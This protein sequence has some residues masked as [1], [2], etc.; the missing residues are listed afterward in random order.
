MQIGAHVSVAGGLQKA[1]Q[2][3]QAI[4]A[5]IL[6]IFVSGPQS[7][8]TTDYSDSQIE[9]FKKLYHSVGFGG[10][11][12]HAIYL[13]NLASDRL[14]LVER[15]K[16]SLI[17]Y[18]QM[19][20]RLGAEGVIVHVGSFNK[21][22]SVSSSRI[23]S[24]VNSSDATTDS[25]IHPLINSVDFNYTQVVESIKY[26]LNKT[27]KSQ[28]FIIE[29]CA[30][31][32]IGKDLDESVLLQKLIDSERVYFCID[33]QHLFASGIDV[34]DEKIFG[35]WLKDFDR[36]IGI[37]RLACIHANDSKSEL[38]S[39]HDRHENIGMG[40]IGEVGFSNILRQPLLQHKP[41]ILE[42]PGYNGNGP[43]RE[44]IQT[45]RSLAS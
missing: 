40:K 27:P 20:D 30:G 35:D 12:L 39:N 45:L 19:G 15:S 21:I 23:Y 8:R 43:D 29:N 9:E 17:H 28:K 41:F 1:V 4:G 36:H 16:A 3:G 11:F 42:V 32:K 13:I 31:G 24:R 6:Q 25:N 18:M 44:N 10:L 33:T 26:I 34:R 5:D 14:D 2:K 37:D 7:Y 38:G 22:K